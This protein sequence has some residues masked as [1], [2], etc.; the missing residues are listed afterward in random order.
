MLLCRRHHRYL[1]EHGFS[2]GRVDGAPVFRDPLG[3]PIAA[4]PVRDPLAP[5]AF[6]RLARWS[7]EAGRVVDRRSNEPGWDGLP[8]NYDL[9]VGALGGLDGLQGRG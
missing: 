3:R 7:G 5:G 4:V 2:L 9:C 1:H 8:V 6:E